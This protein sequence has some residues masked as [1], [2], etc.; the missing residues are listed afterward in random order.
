M[1][2]IALGAAVAAV[3]L[4]ACLGAVV[5]TTG[6]TERAELTAEEQQRTIAALRPPKRDRPLIAILADNAGTET[7]DFLVPYGVLAESNLA[8]VIAVAPEATP[9]QLMPALIVSPQQTTAEFDD[10]HPEGADYVIVPAMHRKDSPRV[11]DWIRAQS[12]SGA[13]IVGICSG[14]MVVAETGLLAHRS[15]TTHW[16]D[17]DSLERNNP[18]LTRV[19]DRR[20]VVDHG[21]VTTTGVTA[22]VPVSLALVEAIGGRGEAAALARRLGAGGDWSAHH[23]SAAFRLSWHSVGLAVG[24]WFS[25]WRHERIGIR[26]APGVDEIALAFTADAYSRTYQSK[27]AAIAETVGSLQ[28]KRGLTLIPEYVGETTEMDYFAPLSRTTRPIHALD[29]VLDDI[30]VRYGANVASFVALQLE[31]SP[32]EKRLVDEGRE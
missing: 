30:G 21:F 9:I 5:D 27:A 15:A 1:G 32:S 12:A 14:A 20:Y 18:T 6:A 16:F 19:D 26:V 7:T 23:D 31:Y 11:L 17:V 10:L 2:S 3:V 25:F 8:D 29:A 4:T 24:N 13:I 28:T 22:S